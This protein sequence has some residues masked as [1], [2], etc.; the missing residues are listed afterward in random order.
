MK[1]ENILD[2]LGLQVQ[3]IMD[4]PMGSQH[5]QYGFVYPVN[6]GHLQDFLGGDGEEQDAYVLGVDQ[7]LIAFEGIVAAVILRED[8]Q[9][10][11]LV[12]TPPDVLLTRE[13]IA[14][15]VAFQEQYF[16]SRVFLPGDRM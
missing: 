3:V 12:V 7:A 5:P 14:T 13:E 6:Y 10:D 8:D 15:A 1:R 4:R 11:K 9:E 2:W 16:K